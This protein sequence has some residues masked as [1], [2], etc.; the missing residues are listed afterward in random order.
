[1]A[2]KWMVT[3]LLCSIPGLPPSWLAHAVIPIIVIAGLGCSSGCR[4][5]NSVPRNGAQAKALKNAQLRTNE[6]C[7]RTEARCEYRIIESPDGSIVVRINYQ[8]EDDEGACGGDLY[9][10][11]RYDSAGNLV[12]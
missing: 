8:F 1:M 7:G 5:E 9:A 6:Y 11:K 4:V 10:E 2:Q 3:P 12:R